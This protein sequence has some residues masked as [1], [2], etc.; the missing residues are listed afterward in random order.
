LDTKIKIPALHD[1]FQLTLFYIK[2]DNQ[3]RLNDSLSATKLL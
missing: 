1:D 2:K 3:S